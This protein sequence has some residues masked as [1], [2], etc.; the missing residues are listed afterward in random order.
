[1]R[2]LHAR[3]AR[4]AFTLP[5]SISTSLTLQEPI[6]HWHVS[7]V[8]KAFSLQDSSGMGLANMTCDAKRR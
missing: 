6:S 1:M 8:A 4:Y 5:P 2:I 3:H 7:A